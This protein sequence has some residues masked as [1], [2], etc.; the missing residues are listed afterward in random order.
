MIIL[1]LPIWAVRAM[2]AYP[3]RPTFGFVILSNGEILRGTNP[4]SYDEDEIARYYAQWIVMKRQGVFDDKVSDKVSKPMEMME[5]KKNKNGNENVP[6][7]NG[8]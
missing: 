1:T 2:S 4:Y 3:E 8:K 7:Q 6:K 5:N